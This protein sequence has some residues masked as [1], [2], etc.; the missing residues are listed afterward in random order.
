[1]LKVLM[2]GLGGIGQRHLR[3]LRTLL[4]KEVQVS[5]W[6]VRRRP[7]V[8][9][10]QLTLERGEDLEKK[11]RIE[12][13]PELLQALAAKPD[14]VLVTNPSSLHIP[15]AMAAAEAGCHLFIE[16]PL[17]HNLDG[18]PELVSL[19]ERKRLTAL[20]GYQ[21]RFHPAFRQIRQW[22]AEGEIG[23]PLSVRAE[24]GEF[25][26]GF[27][28]YENYREMYAARGDLGGG[29]V[30][31]QIH[32][33]DYLYALFGM[34]RQVFSLGGHLSS[35]E[36]EVEDVASTLLECITPDGRV[37]P[38]HLL[39]DYI[40]RP[41]SRTCQIIGNEGKIVWDYHANRIDLFDTRGNSKE[42]RTFEG[43]QR[44][45]MFLDELRH[46][47]RCLEGQESPR[48]T[49]RDGASSLQIALAIRRS[50]ET[51][52]PVKVE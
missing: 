28:P 32:E 5:A 45:Q 11:Y 4:G 50:L 46:Y 21:I 39:Q 36:I 48:V 19:V 35:L 37:L 18:V 14:V 13:F 31:T 23:S 9:T 30:L 17:S 25:L 6:R 16:K 7:D 41:P 26:P 47:L 22:L 49:L 33:L 10:D 44:N 52:R 1:M 20:V 27:H 42:G 8:L 43:F 2:V 24:V 34:P 40:Q 3:N 38:V 51:G 15:V 29:V 12:V